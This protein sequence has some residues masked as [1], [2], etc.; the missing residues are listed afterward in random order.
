MSLQR[1]LNVCKRCGSRVAN[2][3][4]IGD[5]T[6]GVGLTLIRVLREGRWLGEDLGD[7]S[8]RGNERSET[9]SRTHARVLKRAMTFPSRR[10]ASSLAR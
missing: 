9:A 3:G 5:S 10:R 2:Q 6:T 7:R 1:L 8:G 4:S